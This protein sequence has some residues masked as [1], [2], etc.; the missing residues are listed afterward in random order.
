MGGNFRNVGTEIK[1]P[2]SDCG[3]CWRYNGN[4]L[5]YA[6][7]PSCRRNVRIQENKVKLLRSVVSLSVNSTPTITASEPHNDTSLLERRR[8]S[9]K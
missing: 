4:L 1:C 9:Y 3:Y 2:H 8:R 5:R 6:T 7:C